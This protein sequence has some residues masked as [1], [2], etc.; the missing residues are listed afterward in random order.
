MRTTTPKMCVVVV[1]DEMNPKIL[2]VSCQ[3]EPFEIDEKSL[4][5]I[6]NGRQRIY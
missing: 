4:H 1:E 2:P 6:A 5:N 3:D